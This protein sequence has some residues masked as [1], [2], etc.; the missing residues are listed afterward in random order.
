M[1]GRSTGESHRRS[2]DPAAPTP[3][4]GWVRALDFVASGRCGTDCMDR[5]FDGFL[6]LLESHMFRSS[7]L[8][9]TVSEG[10]LTGLTFC[11][12]WFAGLSL[13]GLFVV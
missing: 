6:F 13:L 8:L 10:F 5:L 12:G 2:P 3:F 11:L 9:R 1:T 7:S 4:P